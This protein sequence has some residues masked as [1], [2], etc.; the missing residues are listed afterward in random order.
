MSGCGVCCPDVGSA[1]WMW[2][3]DPYK[4]LPGAAPHPRSPASPSSAPIPEGRAR[5][6]TPAHTVHIPGH[7]VLS[8]EAI[9]DISEIGTGRGSP[10]KVRF[11]VKQSHNTATHSIRSPQ[12]RGFHADTIPCRTLTAGQEGD[13]RRMTE[14]RE[15]EGPRDV[16]SHTG[17]ERSCT[18]TLRRGPPPPPTSR[19]STSSLPGSVSPE[20]GQRYMVTPGRPCPDHPRARMSPSSPPTLQGARL[21]LCLLPQAHRRTTTLLVCRAP[22]AAHR[23]GL[24]ASSVVPEPGKTDLH[25]T[26]T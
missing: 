14:R 20:T 6:C 24:P 13:D 26:F 10:R 25:L 11:K 1:V 4:P 9:P 19:K 8:T 12:R 5:T 17:A 18:Q 2:G 23:C 3:A 7:Q 16:S 21:P 15:K 22:H